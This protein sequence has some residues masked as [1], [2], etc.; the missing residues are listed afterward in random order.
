[1][2]LLTIESFTTKDEGILSL[3]AGTYSVEQVLSLG[4][5]VTIENGVTLIF[6][7]GRINASGGS[8]IQITGHSTKIVAPIYEIIGAGISIEGTWDIDDRAYPQWFEPESLTKDGQPDSSGPISKALKMKRTGEVFLKSGIYYLTSPIIIKRG[9]QLVGENSQARPSE[10]ETTIIRPAGKVGEEKY[11]HDYMLY[12]NSAPNDNGTDQEY[13]QYIDQATLLKGIRFENT[14]RHNG[15]MADTKCVFAK[16]GVRFDSVVWYNF[17]QAIKY[18][19]TYNDL[20]SVVNCSFKCDEGYKVIADK[21]DENYDPIYTVDMYGLGDALAFEHNAIHDTVS[22]LALRLFF[23]GGGL[24]QDNIINGDV[25]IS[26][27]KAVSFNNNHCEKGIEVYIRESC[28]TTC[29][30]Y[31]HRGS[32]PNF[33]IKGSDISEDSDNADKS[34]VSMKNDMFINLQKS[35]VNY[36]KSSNKSEIKSEFSLRADYDITIDS[37]TILNI[38]NVHRYDIIGEFF[39]KM[40]PFGIAIQKLDGGPLKEFNDYS[41]MASCHSSIYG[42]YRVNIH[43]TIK[44]ASAPY[45]TTLMK[46][47]NVGWM[48]NTGQYNY[49]YQILWDD[50]R[51]LKKTTS[52]INTSSCT[53]SSGGLYMYDYEIV[54]KKGIQGV[55]FVLPRDCNGNIFMLRLIRQYIAPDNTERLEEVYVPLCGTKF[56]YDNGIS[57]CGYKWRDCD[58]TL[59]SLRNQTSDK[60]IEMFRVNNG[61]VECFTKK[62]GGFNASEGWKRGDIIYNIGTTQSITIVKDDIS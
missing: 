62:T 58:E 8:P 46:N 48:R 31:M 11:S 54:D 34:I 5:D 10:S 21:D 2:N 23:C 40:Y 49:Y 18:T 33:R 4:L 59:S 42:G 45:I 32:R 7:G 6:N 57:V 16:G 19:E 37:N 56:F 1:M 24:I 3:R 55:L 13:F 22:G 38:E 36:N 53:Y 17:I 35:A 60:N 61:N 12:I 52:T 47:S 26:K 43:G 9:V 28:V 15:A 39:D 14:Q 41:Y 27:S 25:E 30:N 44:N 51:G 50:G 20:K 29:N